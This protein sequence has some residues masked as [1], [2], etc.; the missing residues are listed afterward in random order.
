MQLFITLILELSVNICGLDSIPP[1]HHL[2]SHYRRITAN[3]FP[4]HISPWG[5]SLVPCLKFCFH[6][7]LLSGNKNCWANWT[8]KFSLISNVPY[9]PTVSCLLHHLTWHSWS[10]FQKKILHWSVFFWAM[11]C[12]FVSVLSTFIWLCYTCYNE[13]HVITLSLWF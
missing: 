12:D 10:I 9:C 8:S 5:T 7:C 2:N 3:I 13:T 4:C 11:A 6:C 1:S